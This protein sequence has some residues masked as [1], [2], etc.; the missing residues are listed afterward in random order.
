M[1]AGV[2]CGLVEGREAA[3]KLSTKGG[4]NK[5]GLPG[6]GSRPHS[7]RKKSRSTLLLFDKPKY[8]TPSLPPHTAGDTDLCL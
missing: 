1:R 3:D 7:Q 2:A 5:Q 8:F 4:R 6:T